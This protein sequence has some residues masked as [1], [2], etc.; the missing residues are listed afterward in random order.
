VPRVRVIVAEGW[1]AT[2]A[3]AGQTETVALPLDTRD[4]GRADVALRLVDNQ[5]FAI[6][7]AQPQ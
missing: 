6:L 4:A 7:T 2:A 3:V 1:D 5:G